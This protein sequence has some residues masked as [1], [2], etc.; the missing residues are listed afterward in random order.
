MWGAQLR[1]DHLLG[2]PSCIGY[3]TFCITARYGTVLVPFDT[4]FYEDYLFGLGA[5]RLANPEF[6]LS[7]VSRHS[8]E[9]FTRSKAEYCSVIQEVRG[10][11]F[12]IQDSITHGQKGWSRPIKP[13]F[14]SHDGVAIGCN[15]GGL[16]YRR[17]MSS[18]VHGYECFDLAHIHWQ[19]PI[20]VSSQQHLSQAFKRCRLFLV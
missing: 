3:D 15:V 20:V 16:P 9:I 17:V 10:G 11:V 2:S 4:K 18:R 8:N 5:H 1:C 14:C 19:T 7:T 6:S 13:G 12:L